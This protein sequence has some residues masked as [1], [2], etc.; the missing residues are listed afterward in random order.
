[1]ESFIQTEQ[2]KLIELLPKILDNYK[3][4]RIEMLAREADNRILELQNSG[5]LS[6]VLEWIKR[7]NAINTIRRKL[8][9]KLGRTGIH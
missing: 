9:D 5:D 3:M 8:N 6:Q 1:M 2:M 7:K 4:R